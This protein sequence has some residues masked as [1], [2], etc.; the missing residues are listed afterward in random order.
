MTNPFLE[1]ANNPFFKKKKRVRVTWQHSYGESEHVGKVVFEDKKHLHVR[2]AQGVM[3]YFFKKIPH[4]L[5]V[6]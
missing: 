5:E 4:K 2:N 6:L 3:L 1:K